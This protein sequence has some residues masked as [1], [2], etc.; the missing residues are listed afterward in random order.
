MKHKLLQLIRQNARRDDTEPSIRMEATDD[1]AHIYVY[2][3]IDPYW[4]ANAADLI[5]A[6]ASAAGRPVAMHINSPGGDVIESLSMS[7]AVASYSGVVTSYIDG[8][9]ASAATRLALSASET[10]MTDGGLWMIHNAW[11]M[12]WGNKTELRATADL[13]DKVDIGIAA[14]YVRKTGA[15][16]EQVV[17]WMDATTW[18]TA[19]EA[20]DAGFIDSVVVPS[21]SASAQASAAR[22]NLSAYANAPKLQAPPKRPDQAEITAQAERLMRLNRSR[23]AALAIPT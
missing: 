7:A 11:T 14:D 16:T 13:L 5:K 2:D 23:L 19:Q 20:K 10:H 22:W 21:Q 8:M 9:A 1:Q 4:G 6:L 17:A 15:S 18:F 12:G 3:V